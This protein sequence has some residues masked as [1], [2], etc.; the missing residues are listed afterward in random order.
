MNVIDVPDTTGDA[1]CVL[2]SGHDG[3]G[4]TLVVHDADEQCATV[5]VNAKQARELAVRLMQAADIGDPEY[6]DRYR[7]RDWF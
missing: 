4:V 3:S 7:G 2:V 6:A 1:P 5:H